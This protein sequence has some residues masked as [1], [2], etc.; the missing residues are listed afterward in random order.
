MLA[1]YDVFLVEEK[2]FSSFINNC[3]IFHVFPLVNQK[4]SLVAFETLKR[5]C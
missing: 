3:D 1:F 4:V 5:L 2:I